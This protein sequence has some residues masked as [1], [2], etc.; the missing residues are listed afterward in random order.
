MVL[1][2]ISERIKPEKL[3]VDRGSV[4]YS[5][6]FKSLIK[7]YETELFSTYDDIKAVFIERFKRTLLH[8]IN[9]P[10]FNVDANWPSLLNDADVTFNNSTHRTINMSPV[11]AFNPTKVRYIITFKNTKPKLK[12]SDYV[13]I[14]DKRNVFSK[15]YT[16]NWNRELFNV[17]EEQKNQPPK[18]RIDGIGGEIIEGKYHEQEI[19]KSKFDFESKNKASKSLNININVN[20][21]KDDKKQIQP[22]ETS[23][24]NN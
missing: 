5:K 9:K 14:A 11:D 15:G 19:I 1:K 3:W 22:S 8:V 4:F 16:S 21:N 24:T 2:K 12:V 10:M 23:I 17:N 18:F 6:I 20:K 7:E 13:R